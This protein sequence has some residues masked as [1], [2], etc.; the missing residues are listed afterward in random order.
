M[1]SRSCMIVLLLM[2][3]VAGCTV[4]GVRFS[5]ED[6]GQG[7]VTLTVAK[8]GDGTVTSSPAGIACGGTCTYSFPAGTLVT[9]TATPGANS[10]FSGWSSP[11]CPGTAPCTPA[12]LGETTTVT[13]TFLPRSATFTVSGDFTVPSEVTMVRVLVVGGGG[14]GANGHQGGGGS[15]LVATAMLTVT[16]GAVVPVTVGA[17][18]L[19]AAQTNNGSN[20][21]IGNTP[22]G[23]SSF[24]ALLSARGG[25]TPTVINGPG[26]NGGSGGGGACNSGPRG[27]AG[28]AGGSNGA[29]CPSVGGYLGGTGQGSLADA[30]A[31]FTRRAVSA[32]PG[33]AGGVASHA[34]GGGGGGVYLDAAGP[35]AADGA[36]LTFSAKG[37]KGY[38][39]GGGGGSYDGSGIIRIAGGNGASGL[40]YVEW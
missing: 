30:L 27:G 4:D 17:G 14:G 21:I 33:G 35:S 10:M 40:V 38:G 24:G 20:D 16:P 3:G 39:A 9:L 11:V 23:A 32:A 36:S 31:I 12:I 15:G 25:S 8:V 1:L 22:G 18:G 5:A 19:G 26:A 6:A 2:A 28:G 34:G 7:T 37:G 13:A 29:T